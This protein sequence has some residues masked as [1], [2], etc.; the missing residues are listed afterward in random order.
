MAM[1]ATASPDTVPIALQ[2]WFVVHFVADLLFALPLF[3][4]PRQFLAMLGWQE[5][6]PS[7]TRLVAAALFA[8][9][10][11]SFI[12]RHQS[13]EAFEA[14][15]NLKII[16]STCAIAGL[17]WSYLEG[18]PQMNAGLLLVFLGFSAVWWRYRLGLR[19]QPI[20][21]PRH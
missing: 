17:G 5:V 20:R 19:V 2:R 13:R 6:D 11:Q 18:G 21:N 1:N 14:M 10:I 3:F 4:A 16:W 8:V 7:A 12:G 9:G 15:L